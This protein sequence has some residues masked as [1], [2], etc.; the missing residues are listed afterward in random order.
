[1]SMR[2]TLATLAATAAIGAGSLLAAAGPA[3]A[4]TTDCPDNHFCL[5]WDAGFNGPVLKSYQGLEAGAAAP[6]VHNLDDPALGLN[7]DQTWNDKA[8]SALNNTNLTYCVSVDAEYGGDWYVF[9]PHTQIQDFGVE[10][11]QISSFRRC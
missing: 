10:T 5:F 3:G 4:A 1:M 9:A 11:D 8:G 2:R 7:W 6:D